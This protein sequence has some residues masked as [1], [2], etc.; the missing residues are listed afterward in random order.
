MHTN[1]NIVKWLICGIKSW[2]SQNDFREPAV[3]DI[4][5]VNV[6][7]AYEVQ[8]QV[9]FDSFI[10]CLVVTEL[11]HVQEKYYNM[12]NSPVRYNGVRWMKYVMR[13]M[14]EFCHDMWTERCT[15]VVAGTNEIHERRVRLN[16]WKKLQMLRNE[17]W[18]IPSVCRDLLRRDNFFS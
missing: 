6:H 14:M 3:Y 13:T 5:D 9:V 10:Q 18:K 12:S 16:A 7:E 2:V 15:I 11:R 4:T 1:P 17:R 8:H